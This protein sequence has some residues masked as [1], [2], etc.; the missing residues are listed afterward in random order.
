MEPKRI[1]LVEDDTFTRE[2]Y[3]EVLKDAGFNIETAVDGE[4][5]LSKI[6]IGGFDLILL[7]VMM[8]KK[9][10]LEVLRDLKN[11]P[12]VSQNGQIVLLTNLTHDPV[13]N[14]A[15]SMG[16]KDHLVKS[17]ITPGELVEKVREYLSQKT[18]DE[19]QPQAHPES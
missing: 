6:K 5:G 13:I 16:V 12:P 1:L 3:E 2:L 14:M 15:L 10:G 11:N 19:N 9:D 4:D 7:D 8:P 18:E 17:D